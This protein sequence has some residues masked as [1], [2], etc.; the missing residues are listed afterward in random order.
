MV[1]SI[2]GMPRG[3]AIAID[4]LLDNVAKIQAGQE[5]LLLAH[6]DGLHGSDNL[7]DEQAI[8]WIQSAIH[9]RGANASVLWIDEPDK[10]L[11]WRVPPVL[12]GAMSGCD[13]I[14]NH[15]FNL[16]TEDIRSLTNHFL[17]LGIRYVRNFA[18]TSALL[19]TAW[20]QTPTELVAEIRHQASKAFEAGASWELTDDNGTHLQG[21]ILAPTS[22]QFP[23][24]AS[25]REEGI[26]YLPW[27]EWVNPPILLEGAAGIF[28]FDSMLSWWSRYIG[29]PPY[30]KESIRLTIDDGRIVKIEGG[31]EADALKRFL[32]RMKEKVGDYV[33]HFS[34]MHTGVHPQ[35]R[36][37]PHQCPN[38]NYRRVI[39]HSH[40]SN[41]HVH[42]GSEYETYKETYP[43][44]LHITGDIR[45]ATWRV[46]D[47]LVHDRG[48]LM[49]LD[50]PKVLAV[51]EKYPDRPGLKPEP[52]RY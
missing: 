4:D 6:I 23:T 15:S 12:K 30:F 48:R 34:R 43:Y 20:A 47:T 9:H 11:A 28:V 29:I 33:Y 37:G 18:T 5:V 22:P 1:A 24:Y 44:W 19:N 46:G 35:A 21:K 26:G 49:A 2:H 42:I 3:V 41:I 16:V 52:W 14:I 25:Y 45:T 40:T 36:V 39:D 38:S 8:S 17:E 51:A 31:E 10:P 27:P 7:V 32:E 13:V 50:H